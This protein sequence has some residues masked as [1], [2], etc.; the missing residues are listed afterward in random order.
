MRE[1]C[2]TSAFVLPSI[3]VWLRLVAIGS[4]RA[5]PA[6]TNLSYCLVAIGCDRILSLWCFRSVLRVSFG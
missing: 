5:F 2:K 3:V 6:C 1:F 4:G